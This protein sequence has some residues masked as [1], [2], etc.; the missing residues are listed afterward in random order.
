MVLVCSGIQIEPFRVR[1]DII[2]N[3][4]INTLP[5]NSVVTIQTDEILLNSSEGR[6]VLFLFSDH[7][8]PS[9]HPFLSHLLP[10]S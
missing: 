5:C 3:T 6:E 1:E 9:F 2:F 7:A 8:L 4:E 10:F